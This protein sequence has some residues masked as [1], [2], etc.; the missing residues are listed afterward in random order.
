MALCASFDFAMPMLARA[1]TF[2]LDDADLCFKEKEIEVS[3][4]VEPL[5]ESIA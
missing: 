4:L 3:R 5:L 2:E 1:F